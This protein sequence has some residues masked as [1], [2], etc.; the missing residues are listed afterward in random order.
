M[1]DLKNVLK[2]VK[3]NTV[4][5]IFSDEKHYAMSLDQA[6]KMGT[7]LAVK[8]VPEEEIGDWLTNHGYSAKG[9]TAQRIMK[10]YSDQKKRG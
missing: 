1:K 8:N 4:S 10:A 3:S 7:Q 9:L 2:E 5:K 6:T